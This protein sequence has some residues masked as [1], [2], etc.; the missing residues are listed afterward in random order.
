MIA[1]RRHLNTGPAFRNLTARRNAATAIA[2]S[3]RT[4]EVVDITANAASRFRA[5]AM[6]DCSTEIARSAILLNPTSRQVACQ[7]VQHPRLRPSDV[8]HLERLKP[9]PMVIE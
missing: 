5:T 9:N 6:T 3:I 7:G 4:R 1:P 2:K 8:R